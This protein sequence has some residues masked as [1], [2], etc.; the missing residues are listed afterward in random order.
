MRKFLAVCGLILMFCTIVNVPVYALSSSQAE[1]E[2]FLDEDG[3]Y[4][5]IIDGRKY[6]VDNGSSGEMSDLF[7]NYTETNKPDSEKMAEYVPQIQS[8]TGTV[9]SVIIYLIFA[10]TAS[11]TACD[12]LYIGIPGLRPTLC[13]S[14]DKK[15]L[16]S[17]EARSLTSNPQ[18]NESI[19]VRYFKRRAVSIVYMVVVL[20]LLVTTSLFTDMGLNIGELIYKGVRSF[21]GL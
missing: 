3:K 18:V 1:D 9:V 11:T 16:V 12:L 6:E 21:L 19:V 14:E 15:G 2:V 10:L 17:A 13:P 20:M 4:Y 7:K 8:T 5:K